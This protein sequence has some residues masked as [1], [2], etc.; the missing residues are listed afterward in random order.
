MEMLMLALLVLGLV[1]LLIK[2]L[3]F[4]ARLLLHSGCGFFCLWLLNTTAFFTGIHLPMN[5][6]TVL[7]A[8]ILG[9]PGIGAIALLTVL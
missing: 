5:A 2:P 4:A 9:L 7:T 6:V 1:R 8:G 3:T